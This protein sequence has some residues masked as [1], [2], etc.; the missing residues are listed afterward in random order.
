MTGRMIFSIVSVFLL[1]TATPFQ[2]IP[3]TLASAPSYV[4][5]SSNSIPQGGLGI[6]RIKTEPGESPQVNWMKKEI[7]LSSREDKR[8]WFGF[9][10]VDLK[11]NPGTYRVKVKIMPSGLEEEHVIKVV[12]KDYGERRL[13][14]PKKMVDLDAETLKRVRKKSKVMRGLW[15]PS[16]SP[17][18]W[19]GPFI[20][21]LSGKVIGPF[22]RRSVINNQ[23]RSPHSG[24][25]FRAKRGTPIKAINNGRV[26]LTADQFFSGLSVFID[27]GGGILSMYFHLDKIIAEKG[28]MVTK[29]E[30]VGHVGSTGRATGPHLHFGIRA[31]GFRVDP[32]VLM[33]LSN[34]LEVD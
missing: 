6:I 1:V 14:L 10:G 34:E 24:I 13:T 15:K 11:G 31:N 25:D 18:L 7:F 4:Y 5:I 9:L 19:E 23:P 21:P 16:S 17:P 2:R 3:G 27:H 26:V 28:W 29:G 32:L 30:V 33:D 20:R 12:S 8:N 22:G